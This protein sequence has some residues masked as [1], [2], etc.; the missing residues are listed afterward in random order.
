MGYT[1]AIRTER[2]K[3]MKAM[4][5]YVEIKRNFTNSKFACLKF[6]KKKGKEWDLN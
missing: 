1:D 3:R 4:E 2:L 6:E 5:K